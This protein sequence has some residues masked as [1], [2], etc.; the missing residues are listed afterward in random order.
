MNLY[1]VRHGKTVL[2]SMN[3]VQGWSDAPL[4]KEGLQ[5][6][7]NTAYGLSHISFDSVYSSDTTRAVETAKTIININHSCNRNITRL[8]GL[9]EVNFGMFEG[10]YD[11]VMWKQI[12]E[13][14]DQQQD[15]IYRLHRDARKTI[16]DVLA[17]IDKHREA[18]SYTQMADVLVS[19]VREIIAREEAK[20]SNNILIVSHGA[21][22]GILMEQFGGTDASLFEN[23]SV[24]MVEHHNGS[25][26]IK[27]I[28]DM[29][30]SKKGITIQKSVKQ[31]A[32]R[33]N[34]I[35]AVQGEEKSAVTIYLVRHGK[36]LFNTAGRI[37][38]W[39]DSPL[40]RDGVKVA[41]DLGKGLC[42]VHFDQVYTS[43]LYRTIR[44]ADAILSENTIDR[45]PKRKELAGL[46]EWHFGKYE[47]QTDEEAVEF[48]MEE[49][50]G[51]TVADIM[52]LD[53]A[54]FKVSEILQQRDD[55]GMM[56]TYDNMADRV[57][58][59]FES[60]CKKSAVNGDENILVVSHWNAI[61]GVLEKLGITE[62]I[63][64]ENAS[65]SK[66]VYQD[67]E[68]RIETVN[69][70]RYVEAGRR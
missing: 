40:T 33:K 62:K 20:R 24:S 32:P 46:R 4:L 49:L 29:S 12:N 68:Y 25:F 47:G 50:G 52:A 27:S 28:N 63:E 38:G 21:A 31:D 1:F 36:T 14:I 43:D 61:L 39:S 26:C 35:T 60:L 15:D 58:Q 44:T 23:A 22:L 19:T 6:V 17:K 10:E 16:Y 66:I 53:Q 34:T 42:N 3:R 59:T 5:G 64:I 30:Y 55:T 56:E 7:K 48:V 54:Y 51:S 45:E 9:R 18:T 69:D 8:S 37:Q 2:N 57:F 70:M 67:G 11:H 13:Y 65:V 41:V